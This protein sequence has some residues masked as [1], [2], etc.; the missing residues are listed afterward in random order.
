MA[1]KRALL[2]GA[3]EE[4]LNLYLSFADHQLGYAEK[5]RDL[6][7]LVSTY[8]ATL[9]DI[10]VETWI[11]HGSL[12]GWWWNKKVSLV[13]QARRHHTYLG[14]ATTDMV[15]TIDFPMGH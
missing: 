15:G 9:A 3:Y 5:K 11:M 13:Q 4:R 6:S 14:R 8:L 7:N 2:S 10:G 12:L 1:G